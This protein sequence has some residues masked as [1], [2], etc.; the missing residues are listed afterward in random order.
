M[1]EEGGVPQEC[2]A[3]VLHSYC[4]RQLV[5][6]KGRSIHTGERHRRTYKSSIQRALLS[7]HTHRSTMLAKKHRPLVLT[8]VKHLFCSSSMKD[9][10]HR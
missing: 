9:R 6:F 10:T 2:S 5:T 8:H 7:E 1:V 3:S 4:F